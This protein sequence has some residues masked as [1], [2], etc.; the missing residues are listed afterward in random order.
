[1]DSSWY[2]ANRWDNYWGSSTWTNWSHN[3]GE[4]DE[5]KVESWEEPHGKSG[6]D[7]KGKMKG[8]VPGKSKDGKGKLEGKGKVKGPM[9]GKGLP[10]KTLKGVD[11][12]HGNETKGVPP[13]TN[14]P[15]ETAGADAAP[16]TS[17]PPSQKPRNDDQRFG[18]P[19][20]AGIDQLFQKGADAEG[21]GVPTT[22]GEEEPEQEQDEDHEEED[23]EEEEEQQEAK[24]DE[25]MPGNDQHGTEAN[26]GSQPPKNPQYRS[27]LSKGLF[28][29]KYMTQVVKCC[30]FLESRAWRM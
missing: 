24:A 2:S 28:C 9:T 3:A 27:W 6:K 29:S 8:K 1:M 19:T 23:T 10:G 13:G 5:R 16:P 7:G 12:V 20:Q 11:Q 15:K 17:R 26:Q 22:V 14:A 18:L 25:A 4:A 30:C 21:A